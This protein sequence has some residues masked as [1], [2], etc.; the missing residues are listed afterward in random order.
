MDWKTLSFC[1]LTLDYLVIVY[2]N[3]RQLF[4]YKKFIKTNKENKDLA[5]EL[6]LSSLR[7]R[8][9]VFKI[10]ATIYSVITYFIFLH[11]IYPKLWNLSIEI[12]STDSLL[13]NE[14]IGTMLFFALKALLNVVLNF[15]VSFFSTFYLGDDELN[16]KAFRVFVQDKALAYIFSI[17]LYFPLLTCSILIIRSFYTQHSWIYCTVLDFIYQFFIEFIY[18][19]M[20]KPMFVQMINLPDGD[21]KND[22]IQVCKKTGYN[23]NS[24]LISLDTAAQNSTQ[25]LNIYCSPYFKKQVIIHESSFKKY[26]KEDV[27]SALAHEIYHCKQ[28]DQLKNL[29]IQTLNNGLFFFLLNHFIQSPTS[30]SDFGFEY[31]SLYIGYLV[32]SFIYGPIHQLLFNIFS[33]IL[34][35]NQEFSADLYSQTQLGYNNLETLKKILKIENGDKLVDYYYSLV[36]NN[37]PSVIER[38][39]NLELLL[40]KSK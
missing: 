20:V 17:F 15:P 11:F 33:T 29:V 7:Y 16:L 37:Y 9:T 2:L 3:F 27:V 4:T 28:H 8:Q 23:T 14:I 32:F 12:T 19:P 36:F 13:K 10:V 24:V 34:V 30:F 25:H 21:L 1:S 6:L 18:S 40:K 22:I 5:E 39:K 38:I 35:R 31:D 26:S